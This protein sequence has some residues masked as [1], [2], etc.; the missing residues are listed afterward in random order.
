MQYIA[1]NTNIPIPKLYGTHIHNGELFI[2]MEYVPGESLAVAW[3]DGH[4]TSDQNLNIAAE[5]K[6]HISTLRAL[7][8]PTDLICSA[9]QNP[10]TDCRI[11]SRFFGPL[12][13]DEFHSLA[14]GH[15]HRDDWHLISKEMEVTHQTKY[16]ICFTHADLAPRNIMVKNGRIVAIIDWA[17]SGWYPEYWD[18][19]KAHYVWNEKWYEFIP[20]AFPLYENELKTEAALWEKLPEPGDARYTSIPA[21]SRSGS[22]PSDAWMAQI[23]GRELTDL[24]T[25]PG[26]QSLTM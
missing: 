6:Q 9:F 3:R 13:L 8:P 7:R 22:V 23:A 10:A 16:K 17:F 18:Y 24:W 15:C 26:I 4:L 1:A 5:L 11:G 2:E 21:F 25:T 19:T 14:R 20:L 12:P